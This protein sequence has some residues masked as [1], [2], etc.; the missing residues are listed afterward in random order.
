MPSPS[1]PLLKKGRNGDFCATRLHQNFFTP[2]W[3]L[4]LVAQKNSKGCLLNQS[5]WQWKTPAELE[6]MPTSSK[7]G[8]S[9]CSSLTG[10]EDRIPTTCLKR[11]YSD[12]HS[13]EWHQKNRYQREYIMA[14]PPAGWCLG[15]CPCQICTICPLALG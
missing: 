13:S 10:K 8:G 2:L 4:L 9:G 15:I 12:L 14:L 6:A 3:V 7:I 5:Q 1:F 11:G